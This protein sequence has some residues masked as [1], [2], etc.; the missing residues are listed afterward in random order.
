MSELV[1]ARTQALEPAV[2]FYINCRISIFFTLKGMV[3]VTE[4]VNIKIPVF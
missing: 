4:L 3:F 2:L 1:L